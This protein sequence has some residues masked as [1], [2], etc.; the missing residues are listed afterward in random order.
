[1]VLPAYWWLLAL[2]VIIQGLFFVRIIVLRCRRK[3]VQPLAR[4]V[5]LLLGVSGA[6]G[7]T[8]GIVQRD[9]LFVLGQT[10]LLIIYYM[11]QSRSDDQRE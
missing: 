2:V 3:G 11:I 8:Y 10:C 6:A 1:M 7:L 9:P 5:L 4:P